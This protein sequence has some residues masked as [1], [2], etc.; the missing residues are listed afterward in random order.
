MWP[1]SCSREKPAAIP[2]TGG[3]FCGCKPL[4]GMCSLCTLPNTL[5][6]NRRG[7]RA[8]WRRQP[9]PRGWLCSLGAHGSS[10]PGFC[11]GGGECPAAP[12][13]SRWGK[14]L[15]GLKAP[16]AATGSVHYPS[17]GSAGV[18]LPAETALLFFL[19]AGMVLCFGLGKE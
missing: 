9:L 3:A 7:H 11:Q 13:S 14:S 4:C 6:L 17:G 18:L 12:R 15:L 8:G 2:D 5:W 1:W 19:A 16:T 10:S